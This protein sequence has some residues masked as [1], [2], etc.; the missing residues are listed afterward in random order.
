MNRL[1]FP[2]DVHM[3]DADLIN[4]EPIIDLWKKTQNTNAIVS[5]KL[6]F[7]VSDNTDR[8]N[9]SILDVISGT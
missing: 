3:S 4:L 7:V 5:D 9:V 8:V 6:I 2:S 1:C